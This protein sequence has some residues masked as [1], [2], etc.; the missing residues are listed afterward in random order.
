[1]KK[2]KILLMSGLLVLCTVFIGVLSSCASSPIPKGPIQNEYIGSYA[3]DLRA[4]NG[5]VLFT[6]TAEA[7]KN[8]EFILNVSKQITTGTIDSEGNFYVKT[9]GSF[10]TGLKYKGKIDKNTGSV[11]GKV[12]GAYG[13][14]AGTIE[15][16]RSK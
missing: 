5:M 10:G 13:V 9:K 3:G 15:G 8:G 14:L 1:M 4:P 12:T 7:K 16:E 2:R 6:W 11:K